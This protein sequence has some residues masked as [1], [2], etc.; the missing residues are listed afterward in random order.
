ME[1]VREYT[2][3]E[4]TVIWKPGLCTHAGVCVRMLPQ[5]Y[6]PRLRPWVDPTR[7]TTRQ[8]APGATG[9]GAV[10]PVAE[11]SGLRRVP[12][13]LPESFGSGGVCRPI[14]LSLPDEPSNPSSYENRFPLRYPF[15]RCSRRRIVGGGGEGRH[16]GVPVVAEYAGFSRPSR[17]RSYAKDAW[18]VYYR[19]WKVDGA[20]A[21]SFEDLGGGYG[22][23]AWSVFFE[24]VKVDGASAS[25]FEGLGGGYAKD[26]WNVFYRGKKVKDAS[27]SSFGS[28]GGGYGKDDWT[29][30]FRGGK[31]REAS[32]SSF[33]CLG[34][35]YGKDAWNVFYMGRKLEGV[36]PSAFRMPGRR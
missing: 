28:L 15:V 16:A 8:P 25:S 2:N 32:A 26:D 24:G 34:G 33:E 23:D 36:S 14:S 7:A 13:F 17:G 5:V 22:K 11:R 4:L 21:S 18:N 3:G 20:S 31:V 30:F 9:S 10:R 6:R 35:G 12:C 1:I 29:V 19:G 27:A